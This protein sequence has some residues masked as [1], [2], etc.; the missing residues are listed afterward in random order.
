MNAGARVG[1]GYLLEAG[2]TL[3]PSLTQRKAFVAF[4]DYMVREGET[5]KDRA[6]AL[7]EAIVDGLRHGN[8]PENG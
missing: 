6:I 8:W 1:A 3:A 2:R 4:N 7:A 5:D